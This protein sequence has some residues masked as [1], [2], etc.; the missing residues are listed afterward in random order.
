MM[1]CETGMSRTR[2]QPSYDRGLHDCFESID[3]RQTSNLGVWRF[4]VRRLP[5]ESKVSINR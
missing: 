5:S 2:F 1:I 3:S 4:H